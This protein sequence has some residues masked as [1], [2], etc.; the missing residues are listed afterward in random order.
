MGSGNGVVAWRC[1]G[2]R[3]VWVPSPS[4]GSKRSRRLMTSVATST[5][6]RSVLNAWARNRSKASVTGTGNHAGGLMD[7]EREVGARFQIGADGARSGIGLH[8]EDR[9]G[10]HIGNRHGVGMLIGAQRA[11]PIAVQVEGT[12]ADVADCEREPEH[13]P[14]AGI[15]RR[16]GE[17]RPAHLGG[18][19]Q[20]RLEARMRGTRSSRITGHRQGRPSASRPGSGSSQPLQ[21]RG[22]ARR[23]R[24]RRRSRK[25]H[26]P[27]RPIDRSH[28]P[29]RQPC[30]V[31][32]H[33][34]RKLPG[35]PSNDSER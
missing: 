3:H 18:I 11:R 17:G 2:T 26:H 6:R 8:V 9:P 28:H 15:D 20:V 5:T 1:W 12:Q 27:A 25:D 19:G 21:T 16:P 34:R 30:N 4:A 24:D 29:S 33:A 31:N 35:T 22:G 7:H 32:Q 10:R 14:G 13:R 23:G